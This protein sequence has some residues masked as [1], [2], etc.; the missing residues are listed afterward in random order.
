MKVK[1]ATDEDESAIKAITGLSQPRSIISLLSALAAKVDQFDDFECIIK[2]ERLPSSYR[3]NPSVLAG[4]VL[5]STTF[6]D[7]AGYLTPSSEGYITIMLFRTKK[8]SSRYNPAPRCADI[9]KAWLEQAPQA[10]E[11]LRME[12]SDIP[13]FYRTHPEQLT[14]KIHRETS[15]RIKINRFIRHW[16]IQ[17][18]PQ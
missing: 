1:I 13:S 16:N 6:V 5:P 2:S 14:Y 9:I 15:Q 7:C 8:N 11:V 17:I 3:S 10:K 18:K 12:L 4:K